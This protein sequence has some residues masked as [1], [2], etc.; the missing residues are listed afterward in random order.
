[1]TLHCAG[2]GAHNYYY[3]H[4]HTCGEDGE[5]VVWQVSSNLQFIVLL[6]WAYS[7]QILLQSVVTDTESDKTIKVNNCIAV[8]MH[9]IM[10]AY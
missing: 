6:L 10:H 9:T 7:N 1:M 4:I 8:V 3:K 5:M 2:C